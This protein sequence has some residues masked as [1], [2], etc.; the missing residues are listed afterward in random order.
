MEGYKAALAES[1]AELKYHLFTTGEANAVNGEALCGTHYVLNWDDRDKNVRWKHAKAC[2]WMD[3]I[4]CAERGDLCSK[5]SSVAADK[6]S[7]GLKNGD[8]Y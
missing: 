7:S 4:A 2:R 1:E 6:I 5:C 3:R 8:M